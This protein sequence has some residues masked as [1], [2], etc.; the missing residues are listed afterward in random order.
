M[1]FKLFK[2]L[3]FEEKVL[4]TVN[5]YVGV[6]PIKDLTEQQLK[7]IKSHYERSMKLL[8]ENKER[9]CMLSALRQYAFEL[10]GKD[11]LTKVEEDIMYLNPHFEDAITD[12][13]LTNF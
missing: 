3:T 7:D 2:D 5:N 10:E 6:N 9:F 4:D 11:N 8:E 1:L 12:F 13:V